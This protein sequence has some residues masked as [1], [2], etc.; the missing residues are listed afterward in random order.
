LIERTGRVR[1]VPGPDRPHV[2]QPEGPPAA[3]LLRS[4]SR[5]CYI[6][7][8]RYRE[9]H[10][11]Y[12]LLCPPCARL[13]ETKRDQRADL[14]GRRGLVTGGRIKIGYQA[15]LKL[16][17]D[18]AEVLVTTRFSHEAALRYAGE[19]D[20]ETWRSRLR[21]EQLDLRDLPAVVA[22][23]DGLLSGLPSLDILI[24]NA[25]QTVRR[26]PDYFAGAEAL[27]QRGI[28]A[29][30][31]NIRPILGV[32]PLPEL[33]AEPG[34]APSGGT[35]SFGLLPARQ[36]PRDEPPDHRE[37]NSWTSR[38]ADVGP[39]ELLE[40]L[41]VNA[42]APYLLIGRLRP[43][44]LRS[45]FP[46]RY[47]VNVAG[48]DGRFGRA[49]KTDRHPHVNN[50]QG[51]AEYDHPNLGRRLRPRRD[52]HEQRGCRLG[53]ARGGALHAAADASPGV[54]AAAR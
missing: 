29:L 46:D 39:V 8:E 12:H 31:A 45:T 25:A 7:K 23:A 13:N 53:H 36:G 10:P 43:L 5:R 52:L 47:I 54:R 3:G 17:R 22:F 27:E 18:G 48:L 30:P 34:P 42:T 2:E 21:I 50:E 26:T 14:S 38:L 41:L 49:F 6:C 35:T 15:A 1:A 33:P 24:N 37:A 11:F 9:V 40:V 20:F 19:P 44:F 4:R 32:D 28:A 51:G 16:L